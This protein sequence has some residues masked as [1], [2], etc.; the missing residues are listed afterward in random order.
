[1]DLLTNSNQM[2]IFIGFKIAEYFPERIAYMAVQNEDNGMWSAGVFNIDENYQLGD[3][4]YCFDEFPYKT[5]PEAI[6]ALKVFIKKTMLE[7]RVIS[8]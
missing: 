2:N 3:M 5:E 4:L 6:I 7:V 8:N 1:M